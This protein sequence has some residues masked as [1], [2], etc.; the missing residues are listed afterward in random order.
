MYTPNQLYFLGLFPC[1]EETKINIATIISETAIRLKNN[2]AKLI[3]VCTDN[4]SSNIS[5][6]DGGPF[7]AQQ[8]SNQ[9]F[10]RFP[11]TCHTINLAIKDTFEIKHKDVKVTV[12]E[13]INYFN[14]LSK[15]NK[16]IKN[17]PQFIEVRWFSIYYCVSFILNHKQY[18]NQYFLDNYYNLIQNKYGWP[19]IYSIL[20]LLEELISKLES[21]FSS[22]ADVFPYFT[23]TIN[24]LIEIKNKIPEN[25]KYN[26]ANDIID[27]LLDRFSSTVHLNVPIL[28]F[29]L[30]GNGMKYAN[31]KNEQ[32]YLAASTAIETFQKYA[33]NSPEIDKLIQFFKFFLNFNNHS[34]LISQNS[35]DESVNFWKKILNNGQFWSNEPDFFLQHQEFKGI[36]KIFAKY[37]LEIL[38]IPCSECSV[39]RAFSHLTD[40]LMNNKRNLGFEAIN[41]L[42]IIR[43][44]SIFLIQNGEKSQSFILN[45]M[46]TLCN[47]D[48]DQND[49]QFEDDALI[50]F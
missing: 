40:I 39:E 2:N 37:A 21:D 43:M 32:Y 41:S 4:F 10:I 28:A 3:A 35:T 20:K 38:S 42:L 18:L 46:K 6:L 16:Q 22:V 50:Y 49:P 26:I 17:V 30:T 23:T 15:F 44:N 5:A 29:F 34:F 13:L 47:I 25:F 14:H 11:C 48:Y 24:K 12:I 9:N 8:L 19:Y 45:D 31:N 36:E 7:S 33:I 27:S 1:E